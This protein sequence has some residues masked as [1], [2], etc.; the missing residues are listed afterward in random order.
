MSDSRQPPVPSVETIVARLTALHPKLIDLSLDRMVRLPKILEERNDQRRGINAIDRHD[1]QRYPGAHADDHL[2]QEL[3]AT[4]EA[5][6]VLA[7][8]FAVIVDETDRGEA[9]HDEDRQ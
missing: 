7:Y 1:Q 4:G 8:N 2:H 9:E 6:I 3:G 5:A